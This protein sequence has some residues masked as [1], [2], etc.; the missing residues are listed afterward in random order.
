M[1]KIK[2]SQTFRA[3]KEQMKWF[4]SKEK[5][6]SSWCLVRDLMTK[7]Q[8][9]TDSCVIPQYALVANGGHTQLTII[10]QGWAKY[11]GLWETDKLRLIFC[12][13]WVHHSITKFAF[14]F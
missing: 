13:N 7:W 6:G 11:R 10:G 3:G 8:K 12:H 9:K 1:K 2:Y 4:C 14:I 5:H